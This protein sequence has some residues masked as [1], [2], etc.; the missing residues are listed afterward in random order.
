MPELPD[1]DSG[2]DT[3][4]RERL[5]GAL[6]VQRWVDEVAAAAPYASMDALLKVAE[7]AASPLSDAEIE[8]A[9]SHHP[10]IGE[11]PKGTGVSQSLSEGEQ[12][13]LDAAAEGT[14]AALARGNAVYEERFGRVFLIRAAGRSRA[15]I[16]DELQRRLKLDEEEERIEVGEQLTQIALL[17]LQ[18]LFADELGKATA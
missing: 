10:R 1:V 9:V 8:E 14:A 18:T 5:A 3:N 11:K 6:G 12:A 13:G 15:D 16:L 4:L 17:R 7:D 2:A